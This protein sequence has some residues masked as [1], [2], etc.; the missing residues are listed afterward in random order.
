[1]E[2]TPRII[3]RI[4]SGCVYIYMHVCMY[5]YMYMYLCVY[6]YVCIYIY[7]YSQALNT[8]VFGLAEASPLI[9]VFLVSVLGLLEFRLGE[10]SRG[11]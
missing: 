11:V 10:L 2:Y 1:M 7:T 8:S 6:V 3:I 9:H 4:P 5:V